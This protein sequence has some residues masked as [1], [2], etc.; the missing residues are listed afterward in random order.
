MNAIDLRNVQYEIND[1]IYVNMK[2]KNKPLEGLFALSAVFATIAIADPH[3]ELVREDFKPARVIMHL[4]DMVYVQLQNGD[5]AFFYQGSCKPVL[6]QFKPLVIKEIQ[7]ELSTPKNNAVKL[8]LG[9]SNI[10]KFCLALFALSY[11]FL[12][13]KV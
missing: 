10:L 7:V 13:W 2:N 1:R 5:I 3:S 4:R 8:N 6:S 11:L 9:G 12:W